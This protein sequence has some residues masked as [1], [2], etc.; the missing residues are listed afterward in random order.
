MSANRSE[1]IRNHPKLSVADLIA[2]AAKQGL[3]IKKNLIYNTRSKDRKETDE[4]APVGKKKVSKK[5]KVAAAKV[6]AAP[7]QD[8]VVVSRG[9][10]SRKSSGSKMTLTVTLDVHD[11]SSLK[12]SRGLISSLFSG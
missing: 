6:K 9:L 10:V 3:D 2:E 4:G 12:N 11:P 5:A 1:F 8:P 7:V